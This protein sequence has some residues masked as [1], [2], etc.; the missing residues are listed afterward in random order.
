MEQVVDIPRNVLKPDNGRIFVIEVSAPERKVKLL[1]D[2]DIV[3]A[4]DYQKG[5]KAGDQ[6]QLHR[7]IVVDIDTDTT[8]HKQK[9]VKRGDEVSPFIPEGAVRLDWP[10]VI[11]WNNGEKYYVFHETEIAGHAILNIENVTEKDKEEVKE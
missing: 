9:G 2:L 7:Y 8:L 5:D 1:K 6:I 11:D 10:F 4:K 3:I